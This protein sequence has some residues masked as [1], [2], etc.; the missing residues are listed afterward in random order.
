LPGSTASEPGA[1]PCREPSGPAQDVH[2][3][4]LAR[5]ARQYEAFISY[6]H[7]ADSTL[8][9][10][11]QRAL[12]RLARPAYKWWQWWPPRVFRDQT[13][14]AAASN[15][16]AEIESALLG[17][18]NFVLLASPPAAASPWVDR[19]I[20]TWCANK[21]RERLFIAL[22]DGTLAWDDAR[23]DFDPAR[24][25]ALP[26]SLGGV[27]DAEPLWVDFTR[28]RGDGA[29]ARDPEFMDNAAT[30]AAAIRGTEKDAI[31]GEDLR[32]HRRARQLALGAIATLAA[33]TVFASLAAVFAFVQRDRANERARL[34]TSRQ[35]A[36][37]AVAALEVDPE[38]SLALAARAATT[39][40]T[41]E[42]LN[43]LRRALRGSHLRSSIAVGPLVRDTDLDP[44]GR[45]VAG[46]LEDGSVRTW[47]LRSGKPV[48][49]YRLAREPVRSVSFSGDGRRLLGAGDAGAAVWSTASDAS[50]QPL[51]TFDT[52][53]SPLAGALSPDGKRAATG[54]IEGVVRVWRA[55]TGVLENELLPA[56]ARSPV[57]SVAFS[58]DG[59]H[60][61]AASGARTTVWS[62]GTKSSR[63]LQSQEKDV[64]A[65]AFSP[66]GQRVATGDV[67]GIVRL[68]SL[69]SGGALELSGHEGAITSLAFSSDGRW[70][71]TA[72]EDETGR[73]WDAG[74]GRAVAELRGH[75]G[76]V[77]SATFA[78]DAN[79]VVTGGEDGTI[80][81][82]AVA[83]D[84]VRAELTAD[85]GKT[86]RDIA[87]DRT[88]NQLVTASEDRTARIWDRRTSAALHVLPHGRG[89][90]DWVESAEFSR[91]GKLVLTA[92]DDGTA[93]VW[94]ASSRK[95]LATLGQP[96]DPA[97]Y[98]A[99]LSPDG[100]IV[101]A[102][103][104]GAFVR[105]WRWRHGK[106]VMRL[107]GFVER[108]DGVA[109]SPAGRLVAAAGGKTVRVWR[110]GDGAPAAQ[111]RRERRDD[112]TSLAFHPS[113]ELLAVGSSGGS[114][115]IW[116][117]RTT[118]RVA[119]MTGH[120]DAV[121]AVAFSADGAYLATAGRDGFVNVWAVSSGHL[122]T[123]LRTR[124]SSLE[125]V[126]FA[127]RGREVAVAGAEGR[128]TVFD[129][130]ECRP[131]AAL[132]C[133]AAN[134]V[135]P[136]VRT[137]EADAFAACD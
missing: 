61:V 135:T 54:G 18:E 136:E 47:E 53:G 26:P 82:W 133:L 55:E 114:A 102:A 56:G 12:N 103:G 34:A 20:S 129:C 92:G 128:V 63:V 132:V 7:Q 113:G 68:W 69:G 23:G 117:M 134:R 74:T 13:N 4:T 78:P 85:N 6:S 100:R 46:A 108:V 131:L 95:I 79:A 130:A 120:G 1:R 39:A 90:D 71:V 62:L 35:L 97:L 80:R 32:Q 29:S 107:G 33:L 75:D 115:D 5:R 9:A 2:S 67:D 106:L 118:E 30:L 137:R 119:R 37:E 51:A 49:T 116:N 57:T 84:P 3:L 8:A 124:A 81:A 17:A 14:L 76:L 93:K 25:N 28:V 125:A 96:G 87:Y 66:D 11:L 64:W 40:P 43:A 73:I 65:V 31:V 77:L 48:A 27:F 72:S 88:G 42:A 19:E 21:P 16:G 105:L 121:A 50:A 101:A 36:A 104:D 122:V 45:V 99:A 123:T 98:D 109:F 126:A 127:P 52:R 44:S 24:S 86:L 83:S 59:S 60:V 15:L 22:T 38:Q 112:M 10:E 110:A 91:D 94:E 89:D 111:P 58:A 70:L 41:T